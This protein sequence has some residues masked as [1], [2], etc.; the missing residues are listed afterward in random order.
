MWAAYVSELM[1]FVQFGFRRV[2][3]F[4]NGLPNPVVENL[5]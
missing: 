3:F 5:S 1:A 4:A 2:K